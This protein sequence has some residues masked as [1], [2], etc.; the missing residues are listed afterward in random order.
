MVTFSFAPRRAAFLFLSAILLSACALTSPGLDEPTDTPEPTAT[1]SVQPTPTTAAVPTVEPSPTPVPLTIAFVGKVG[2]AAPGSI[3]ALSLDGV[4]TAATANSLQL[5]VVDIDSLNS[6]DPVAAIR[7]AADRQPV[8]VVVAGSD[9]AEATR[10]AARDYPA[11]KFIGVDQPATDSLPNY[12]VIGDP[13]NRLDEEAF[14]AGMLAGLGSTERI[15][16]LIVP[17]ETL[18]GKLYRNGFTHG[19]RYTCGEC[20]LYVTELIDLND[21]A[22]GARAAG[23][24]KNV[25]VDVIFA[26]AGP[27]G[28]ATLKAALPLGMRVIGLGDDHQAAI[29]AAHAS[30]ALGSVVRRPDVSLPAMITAILGGT[31]PASIPFSLANGNISY[32]TSFGPEMSPGMVAVLSDAITALGM[33]TLDTGVDLTTGDE[34]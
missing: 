10:N 23:Q 11:L 17:A 33:G 7:M 14:L 30:L 24:L 18:E 6:A 22:A 13:G 31:S 12:F 3:T 16:G 15:V 19:L 8:L 5:D 25:K 9:L 4:Q 2:T 21:T 27:A 28:Q 20:E 26:P 29:D 1:G 32:S 34:K